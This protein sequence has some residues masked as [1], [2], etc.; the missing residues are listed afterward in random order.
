[1]AQEVCE[2]RTT[3]VERVV[4]T[5]PAVCLADLLSDPALADASLRRVRPRLGSVSPPPASPD[6][7]LLEGP[8][9]E[10]EDGGSEEE[11][12]WVVERVLDEG[13][14]GGM[15]AE[16]PPL[17][18]VGCTYDVRSIS[19]GCSAEQRQS[20]ADYI[21]SVRGMCNM[22]A[23]CV[24]ISRRYEEMRR[25][26][27]EQRARAGLALMP[28]WN[29]ATV[30]AHIYKHR[31]D[32][33]ASWEL[34]MRRCSALVDK[35][36]TGGLL[37]RHRST[38]ELA[39]DQGKVRAAMSALRMQKELA[40]L[41]PANSMYS[42]SWRESRDLPPDPCQRAP[43]ASRRLFARGAAWNALLGDEEP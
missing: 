14:G 30:R 21:S 24:A 42:A 34:S 28:A 41:D 31:A 36:F 38:G 7:N 1:M 12:E 13:P 43:D 29:P 19:G 22:D 10:D 16:A 17:E 5:A 27:N 15:G 20:L 11:E 3:T 2:R 23:M 25:G 37:R 26:M 9:P 6:N 39:V 32:P 40:G 35:L 33:V 8:P 4:R 18:C